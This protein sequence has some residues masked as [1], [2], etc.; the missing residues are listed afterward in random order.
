MHRRLVALSLVLLAACT[1][2]ARTE[3]PAVLVASVVEEYDLGFWGGLS[4]LDLDAD[5]R[6]VTALLDT[7]LLIRGVLHRDAE[8]RP[9]GFRQWRLVPIEEPGDLDLGRRGLD[10]EGLAVRDGETFVSFERIHAVWRIGETGS[11]EARLPP[12]PAFASLQENAS[13]EALA[14][15]ADG[16]LYTLPERSGAWGRPFPVWRYADGTWARAFDLPRRGRFLPVGA[17]FGPDGHLY[18]L[19]RRFRLPY[20][21]ATRV[22]RF[23][24][25]GGAVASEE[26]LLE[27]AVGTHDNLEGL[28]VW[29]DDAGAIRLTMVSDDNHSVLQRTEIVE[30]RL[31]PALADPAPGG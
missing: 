19:E 1:E 31:P 18:L 12:H 24:V 7:G 20:G 9:T 30:Y 10:A 6:G 2:D 13:L 15:D 25:A 5:A 3:G 28:A 27:T 8:G 21:F 23:D 17:D 11:V 16:A 29:R 14:V 26:T 22:R 4:G